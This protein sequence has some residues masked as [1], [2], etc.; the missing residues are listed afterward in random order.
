MEMDN[1][2]GAKDDILRHVLGFED[3]VSSFST[4][5]GGSNLAFALPV[6]PLRRNEPRPVQ[7]RDFDPR[8]MIAVGITQ[9]KHA[10]GSK[11][12]QN[13]LLILCQ[14]RQAFDSHYAD[15]AIRRARGEARKVMIGQ[16]RRRVGRA[17]GASGP[18]SLGIGRSIGHRKITA[19]TLGCFVDRGGAGGVCILSNNHVLANVNAARLGDVILS[20]GRFD[21]GRDPDHRCATLTSF[22]PINLDGVTANSVDCAVASVISDDYDPKT[23]VDPADGSPFGE[24]KATVN[25]ELRTGMRVRKIGRTTGLTE[26]EIVA[27]EVDNVRVAMD[28]NGFGRTALFNSQI[29]IASR[30]S[31]FSKGGDSGSVI[32][33]E[34]HQPAALLFAGSE[35]RFS[36][37]HGDTTSEFAGSTFANPMDLVLSGLNCTIFG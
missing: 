36:T 21:G 12:E 6:I 19:G 30:S 13:S 5:G 8:S 14:S 35:K 22:V 10:R 27:I 25:T 1:A 18:N 4:D 28:A 31:Q 24:L 15:E 37:S 26:G 29:L 23:L 17:V 9:D 20:P 11:I 33:D 7:V 2:R 3:R 32:F 16:V 34:H